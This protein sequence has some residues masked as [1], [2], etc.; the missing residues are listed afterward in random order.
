MSTE[1]SQ[2]PEKEEITSIDHL[3]IKVEFHVGR[4]VLPASELKSL[5]AGQVMTTGAE[6]RFPKVQ[7]VSEGI[8]FAEGELVDIDGTIGF[9]ILKILK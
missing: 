4:M 8:P 3:P 2:S 1:D 9:R 5:V 6:I 7:A